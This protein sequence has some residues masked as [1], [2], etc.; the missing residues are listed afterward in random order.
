MAEQRETRAATRREQQAERLK[1]VNAL[2]RDGFM[3][4]A[5]HRQT[6]VPSISKVQ[7]VTTKPLSDPRFVAVNPHK[8]YEAIARTTFVYKP[9]LSGMVSAFDMTGY[10]SDYL[11]KKCYARFDATTA[12]G[13]AFGASGAHLAK[14]VKTMRLADGSHGADWSAKHHPDR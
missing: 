3:R 8:A 10:S 4:V 11:I 14:A 2:K 5:A 6:V 12:V 1:H 7:A 13:N 9:L